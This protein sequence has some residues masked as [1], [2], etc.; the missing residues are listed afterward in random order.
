VNTNKMRR[1]IEEQIQYLIRDNPIPDGTIL[2]T[3]TAIVPGRD[4]GLKDEDIV[5]I[6]ISNIGTLITPVKKRRK[7]T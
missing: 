3:G 1:K 4:K 5:E 6:T 2:T 7:I